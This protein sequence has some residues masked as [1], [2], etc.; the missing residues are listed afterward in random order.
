VLAG[1]GAELV[2]E[3]HREGV[4]GILLDRHGRLLARCGAL[5]GSCTSE[6]S[7]EGSRERGR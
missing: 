7:G 6:R 1:A 2:G 4:A 3:H 5:V